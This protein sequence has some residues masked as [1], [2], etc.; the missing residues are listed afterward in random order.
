MS[1]S[2][3]YSVLKKMDTAR[4][5]ID[6]LARLAQAMIDDLIERRQVRD[7]ELFKYCFEFVT[8][9]DDRFPQVIS[10]FSRIAAIAFE[11]YHEYRAK[12]ATVGPN[13]QIVIP[14]AKDADEAIAPDAGD[15]RDHGEDYRGEI[16]PAE[17]KDEWGVSYG[18]AHDD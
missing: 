4:E 11:M 2:I 15:D 14:E 10:H 16:Y 7:P 6:A 3:R 13:G 5:D 9:E 12:G 8:G 18:D 17:D 1:V